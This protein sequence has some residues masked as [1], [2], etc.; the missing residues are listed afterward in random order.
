[1]RILPSVDRGGRWS[2]PV[3]EALGT[4]GQ[5]LA[6]RARARFE[7]GL[8]GEAGNDTSEGEADRLGARMARSPAAG[9]PAS[10]TGEGAFDD[11]R[12]HTDDRAARAA[13]SVGALA[14]TAGNHVVF[15]R[16][17]YRPDTPAGD[18]LLGHELGH[19]LQQ[20]AFHPAGERPLALK[21]R[22][23]GY[24]TEKDSKRYSVLSPKKLKASG[25]FTGALLDYL[26][27]FYVDTSVMGDRSTAELIV[28]LLESS[29]EFLVIAKE[30]DEY[31]A[32][33]KNPKISV[34][35]GSRGSM[36]V[37][38][39]TPFPS[40]GPSGPAMHSI[41]D[42]DIIFIDP[43]S[44]PKINYPD[45]ASTATDDEQLA[46]AFVRV[47]LH[48][49]AHA[50]RH[51]KGR[52]GTGL[53]GFLTDE[54]KTR[55]AERRMLKEIYNATGSAGVEEEIKDQ[56]K[57]HGGMGDVTNL[58]VA[59]SVVSG[60]HVTYLEKYHLDA[61]IESL[62]AKHSASRT[63]LV[64]GLSGLGDPDTLTLKNATAMKQS[65]K[66]LLDVVSKPKPAPVEVTPD[67]PK[68]TAKD[69][70]KKDPP[71]KKEPPA[72]ILGK[73]D[74]ATL[75]ALADDFKSL[76]ELT[77]AVKAAGKL[78]AEAQALFY[79]VILMRATELRLE[80]AAEHDKSTLDVKSKAYKKFC[81]D[82][83][84]KYLGLDKPYD[85]AL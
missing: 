76:D 8:V 84:K 17:Q 14:F 79:Y 1:M 82:L 39:G 16:G 31:Y 63:D 53:S 72:W 44:D 73:G 42:T 35:F 27:M 83:A 50:Y 52:G 4:P 65:F 51:I 33:E 48:E 34:A 70:L 38:A 18:Q 24:P 2:Q 15:G 74:K 23:S 29:P 77:A 37:T 19:V 47:L 30:L 68:D 78:S 64:R 75:T 26:S 62:Y 85:D 7:A 12:V 61:A 28:E 71:K 5:A 6:P 67:P 41:A 66:D 60:D 10:A 20:R 55:L 46:V 45:P 36:F 11:V 21:P 59:L 3:R 80:L 49:A 13:S 40:H 56:V 25:P 22:T 69:T 9:E 81:N 43:S 54:K 57:R 32:N 58:D